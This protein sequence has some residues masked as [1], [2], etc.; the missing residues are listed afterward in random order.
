M[1]I[2]TLADHLVLLGIPVRMACYAVGLQF[3]QTVCI[4]VVNCT[5]L[6]D[7]LR[8]LAI[9]RNG[10]SIAILTRPAMSLE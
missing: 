9:F 1:S 6:S 4:H 3:A 8:F 2:V 7:K 5:I 10:S